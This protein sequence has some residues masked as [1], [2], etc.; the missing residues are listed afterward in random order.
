MPYY[1]LGN[2]EG[3]TD[4]QPGQYVSA[5]RQMLLGLRHL[6]DGGV[7]HRDLKP[8]NLLIANA[9]PF[10]IVIS[11]FG[12]SRY[13]TYDSP[14]K[15]F[16][17]TRRY[18][19]PEV[20]HRCQTYSS[21][22]DI[23]SAGVI[24]VEF[25]YG[26]PDHPSIDDVT[27]RDWVNVWYDVAVQQVNQPERKNDPVID[28]VK[29]MLIKK[30]EARFSASQCLSNGC[31]IGL[32]KSREDGEIVDVDESSEDGASGDE[33][34]DV[35]TEAETEIAAVDAGNSV[36]TGSDDSGSDE[37]TYTQ[38][39]PAQATEDIHSHPGPS[40]VQGALWA[41]DKS[42]GTQDLSDSHGGRPVRELV[43][44]K[45]DRDLATAYINPQT[46]L[47]QMQVPTPPCGTSPSRAVPQRRP[48]GQR[49]NRR[50]PKRLLDSD[51]LRGCLR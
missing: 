21:S 11:D 51:P 22:A 31:K 45:P 19:A 50:W 28:L 30:P 36:G 47:W 4:L 18:V 6:H 23:W 32:F 8:A 39:Q 17:G 9:H 7:V 38:P 48:E 5:F 42:L 46:E 14:A 40:I 13:V 3:R 20:A 2:L 25:R 43:E 33:A 29:N 24:M 27:A 16:C 26:F 49:I 41:S 12:L 44:H 10:I 15:T 34:T 35:D 1:P 37:G